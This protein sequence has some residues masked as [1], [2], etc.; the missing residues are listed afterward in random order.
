MDR[1]LIIGGSGRLGVAIR[2]VCSEAAAPSRSEVDVT[3]EDE[4]RRYVD[5]TDPSVLVNCAAYTDVD[6]AEDDEEQAFATNAAA[7]GSLAR[8]AADRAIPLVI[9]SSDYV[10]DGTSDRAYVESSVPNPINA[11]GRTKH[12]GERLALEYPDALVVRTSWLISLTHSNFITAILQRAANGRVRVVADQVG[13]PTFTEDLARATLEA[14]G[15]G[16]RGI[17][18]LSSGPPMSRFGVAQAAL[19]LAGL[20]PTMAVACTTEEYPR[21]ADRPRWSVLG[22]ERLAS[23]GMAALRPWTD[24]LACLVAAVA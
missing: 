9:F 14:L 5:L 8:I 23:V 19:S 22:S 24:R 12:A 15:C 10:F 18:H 21:R 4:V 2:D 11:Y 7:V 3:R 17:L 1:A 6:G 13:C 16:V 20:D